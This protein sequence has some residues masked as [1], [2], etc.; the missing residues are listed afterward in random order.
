[1]TCNY[2]SGRAYQNIQINN[3]T[4]TNEI[5]KEIFMAYET[6][7][8]S[9]MTNMFDIKTV[10]MLMED[11]SVYTEKAEVLTIIKNYSELAK[12]YLNE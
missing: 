4:M 2:Y 9:G 8:K 5:T 3:N 6:V 11:E 12:K 10:I 1:M 7:R